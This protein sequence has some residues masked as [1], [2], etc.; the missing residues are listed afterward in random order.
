MKKICIGILLVVTWV[1]TATA[2]DFMVEFVRENYKESRVD[3]SD[4][5]QIYHSIQ[6]KTHAGPK[7]LVLTGDNVNYRKWL[8]YYISG[9]RH[10]IARVPDDENDKFVGARIFDIDVTRI[11]PFE[12]EVRDMEK[13]GAE[14]GM[15]VLKDKHILVVDDNLKRSRLISQVIRKLGFRPT[16]MRNSAQAFDTF[17]VQPEKFQMIIA[18]HAVAGQGQESFVD[19]VV[20]IDHQIPILF[21]TGYRNPLGMKQALERFSGNNS[22]RVTPM[23]LK[24]LQNTIQS[25][26]NDKA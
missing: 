24:D 23:A 20:R 8:R 26:I 11:H 3:Y 17:Q 1:S 7:L 25:L 19:R 15:A 6:V 10:F 9:D 13:K 22:V 16:V 5:P 12:P 14:K 21:E 18:N 4:L 2:R